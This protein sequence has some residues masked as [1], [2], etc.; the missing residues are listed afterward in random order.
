M[1]TSQFELRKHCSTEIAF[2]AQEEFI[3]K[4]FE[5]KK[6]FYRCFHDS[7][8]A[9][10]SLKHDSLLK[11]FEF[12]GI[13]GIALALLKPYLRHRC[14]YVNINGNCSEIKIIFLGVPLGCILGPLLF[15]PY[16][17]D[18]PNIITNA[19]FIIYAHDT[20]IFFTAKE[21]DVAIGE[22]NATLS[23]LGTWTD[24][25]A[26]KISTGKTNFEPTKPAY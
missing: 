10:D 12:Y 4:Q 20:S 24:S 26:F 21:C 6:K 22:A 5:D 2:L 11:K 9:F 14:P 3:L 15:N 1:S 8:K 19:K 23:A 16:V 25:N 7:F 18:L 17:N 13:R